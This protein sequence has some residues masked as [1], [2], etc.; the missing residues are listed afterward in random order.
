MPVTQAPEILSLL[1]SEGLKS[2]FFPGHAT[3]WLQLQDASNGQFSVL[4]HSR[5][6][7]DAWTV[8]LLLQ[9]QKSVLMQDLPFILQHAYA[10][11][12][13]EN[14]TRRGL[15]KIGLFPF[16]PDAVL[17]SMPGGRSFADCKW[18]IAAQDT[19][20]VLRRSPRLAQKPWSVPSSSSSSSTSSIAAQG[21]TPRRSPRL[22]KKQ[23]Y[24]TLSQPFSNRPQGTRGPRLLKDPYSVVFSTRADIDDFAGQQR[25]RRLRGLV[26]QE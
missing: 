19:G 10:E 18:A 6:D 9:G 4:K 23:W 12:I 11:S 15:K 14:V 25:L 1:K 16:N 17:K 22:A 8:H 20:P 24:R 21:S 2:A 5:K 7:I 3:D 13:K 26:R